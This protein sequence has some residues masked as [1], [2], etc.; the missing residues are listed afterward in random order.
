MAETIS[1][2]IRFNVQDGKLNASIHN[3]SEGLQD[4]I[5]NAFKMQSKFGGVINDI[6]NKIDTIRLSSIIDQVDHVATGLESLSTPGVNYTSALADLSAIT[7]QTGEDLNYLGSMARQNAKDFGGD[8]ARS[9]EVYKLLLSQLGPNLAKTPELLNEMAISSETLAKTLGGDSVKATQVLTTAMNQYGV[10]INSPIKATAQLKEM[11]NAMAAA[12]KEGSAELDAQ[13][14]AINEVGGDAKRAKIPFNQ[15]LSS[16]QFL[17][18]GGLKES[19][20]GVA[21]RNVIAS[22]NQGRFLPKDVQKELKRA[23]V[24]IK[25]LS[26]KSL[27]FTDRLR[28]LQSIQSDSALLTKLFGRESQG[29]AQILIGS[30]DAQD[31]LTKAISGTNTAY[32]QA[33]TIMESPAE[34]M[35][36][37]KA[38]MDDLKISL[39]DITDGWL[40]YA[41]V[42]GD[43]ARDIANIIPL[44]TGLGAAYS[45]I[46]DKQKLMTLWTNISTKAVKVARFV[47]GGVT[48]ALSLF[49]SAIKYVTSREKIMAL[50]TGITS[51]AVSAK[52]FVVKAVTS[53]TWLWNT[54]QKA[55]N[56]TLWMNPLTWIIA[57]IVGLV[58]L[59]TFLI[60]KIDGWGEMWEHTIGAMTAQWEFFIGSFKLAWLLAKNG[61]LGGI[62]QMK[63]AWYTLKALWDKEGS[64]KAIRDIQRQSNA[65]QKEVVDQVIANGDAMKDYINHTAA[66]VNS[67]SI[68][69]KSLADVSRDIQK[70]LGITDLLGIG[71]QDGIADPKGT[72]G[73]IGSSSGIGGSS[74][75]G[76]DLENE[77]TKTNQAIATGGK[78]NVTLNIS[79]GNMVNVE[80]IK[81]RDFDEAVHEM[82]EKAAD[83]LLRVLGMA[84]SAVS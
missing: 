8:A 58:A 73:A 54:A 38:I 82:E 2:D 36:R 23:G 3:I 66:S 25:S 21:L 5:G 18:K 80:S 75:S 64:Q 40:G 46:T 41:S 9:V 19:R 44:F 55:L 14:A 84:N 53:S 78:K 57:L 68:N 47:F 29:A 32:D 65:R 45:F 4:I 24:D 61:F 59:I 48:L 33:A 56:A 76:K 62:D 22:L 50:W 15:M 13:R 10:D 7:G 63:I 51:A 79:M 6:N 27:S 74:T 34:A 39:F 20:G 67:L 30:V 26:D 37:Q 49:A 17:D 71:A 1:F 35:A 77:G 31:K 52:N 28:A 69:D 42:V 83:A 60:Y 12:A 16:L 70:D 81:G 72:A 11:M 43:S